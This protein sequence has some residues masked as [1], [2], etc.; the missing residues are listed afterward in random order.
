MLPK[1]LTFRPSV[2]VRINSSF[3]S[4]VILYLCAE[5]RFENVKDLFSGVIFP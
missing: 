4:H 1:K 2:M 5:L 3:P